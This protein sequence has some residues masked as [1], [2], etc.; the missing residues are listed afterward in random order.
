MNGS[1]NFLGYNPSE[2]L[3]VKKGQMV[4][5]SKGTSY[6]YTNLKTKK[7]AKKDQSVRVDHILEGIDVPVGLF[8]NAA[9]MQQVAFFVLNTYLQERL[10]KVYGKGFKLAN[11]WPIM[12]VVENGVIMLPLTNPQV[13]W[14]NGQGNCSY[15]DINSVQLSH[16]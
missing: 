2:T 8:V 13:A 3:P 4:S 10:E 5:V 6:T 9:G 1:T 11:L 7:V 14:V 15:V 12:K 16:E